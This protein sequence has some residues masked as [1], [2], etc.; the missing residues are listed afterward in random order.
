M[1]FWAGNSGKKIKKNIFRRILFVT[2]KNIE[3]V[4]RGKIVMH[5][6]LTLSISPLLTNLQIFCKSTLLFFVTEV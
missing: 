6:D 2:Q 4:S 1:Q 5:Q 3:K